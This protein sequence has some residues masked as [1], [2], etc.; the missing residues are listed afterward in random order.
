MKCIYC[1]HYRGKEYFCSNCGAPEDF[2]D[3]VTST[4]ITKEQVENDI[5]KLISFCDLI[6][7]ESTNLSD[8]IEYA[9]FAQISGTTEYIKHVSRCV[10]RIL[11][12]QK[13]SKETFIKQ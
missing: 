4:P 1:G 6:A 3:L 11:E 5:L 12:E 8:L 10:K 9:L 7:C 2:I 13:F